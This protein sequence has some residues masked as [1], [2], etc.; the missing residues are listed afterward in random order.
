[1]FDARDFFLAK[2]ANYFWH[3]KKMRRDDYFGLWQA[4]YMRAKCAAASNER[5]TLTERLSQGRYMDGLW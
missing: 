4:N 2:V 1:M 3:A 5:G